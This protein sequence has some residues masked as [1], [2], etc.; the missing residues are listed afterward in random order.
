MKSLLTFDDGMKIADVTPI[1]R[2]DGSIRKE[3]YR[4]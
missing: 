1:F 4:Q 3:N 2:K